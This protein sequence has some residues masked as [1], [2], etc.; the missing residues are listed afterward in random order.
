MFSKID[1]NTKDSTIT[2]LVV[3]SQRLE[4]DFEEGQRPYSPEEEFF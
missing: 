1:F 4:M 2:S 3:G